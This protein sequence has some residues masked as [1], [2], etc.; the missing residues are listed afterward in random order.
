MYIQIIY[1]NI[2]LFLFFSLISEKTVPFIKNALKKI[3]K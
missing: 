1:W 2:N 3:E